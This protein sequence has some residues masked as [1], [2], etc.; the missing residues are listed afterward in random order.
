MITLAKEI[1]GSKS[2]RIYP[3]GDTHIGAIGC[4]EVQL[5]NMVSKIKAD[6]RGYVILGGDLID[7]VILGDVKR[8]HPN[9]LPAWMLKDLDE[10]EVRNNLSDIIAAQ[11]KRLYAIL[12]PIKDR[13]IGAIEGN[14]EDAICKHH[15]RNV[16][17]EICEHFGC[18]DLTDCAYIRI[19]IGDSGS[20][21]SVVKLFVCHGHGGGRSSGSEPN[22]LFRLAA[23]K[24]IDVAL[25]GHSHT[26]F[27]HPPIPVLG[28]ASTGHLRKELQVREK[29]A[30]NWGA[31][32]M[33][34]PAGPATYASK[35]CYP[36]RPLV[37][38]VVQVNPEANGKTSID[39]IT[40]RC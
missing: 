9:N 27:V 17:A 32:V 38:V 5:K 10:D 35:A 20:K 16:Q 31:W 22:H 3:I 26:Y 15:N 8:F 40:E 37:T 34:Y 4:A 18:P 25:R 6:K 29:C 14:H 28:I 21:K 11:L 2:I 7:A 33:S 30:A 12:D 24:D 13:I 1:K 39:M 19:T 23:D 36:A